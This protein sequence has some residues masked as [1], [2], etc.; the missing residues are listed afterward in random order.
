MADDHQSPIDHEKLDK[1]IDV[2][3]AGEKADANAQYKAGMMYCR[4]NGV[5]Q[6]NVHAGLELLSLA[7]KKG[8]AKAQ[9]EVRTIAD[10]RWKQEPPHTYTVMFAPSSAHPA[11]LGV[12]RGSPG[13][14]APGDCYRHHPPRPSRHACPYRTT[15]A[16]IHGPHVPPPGQLVL[17]DFNLQPPLPNWPVAPSPH[18]GAP[19]PPPPLP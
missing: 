10:Q 11:P 4:G 8:H 13:A 5:V 15:R 17:P 9:R 18:S 14:A 7:A 1:L 16:S 6:K 3:T 12:G 19:P 2:I